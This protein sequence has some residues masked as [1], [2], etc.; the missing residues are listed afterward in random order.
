M[1]DALVS[2]DWVAQRLGE[3]GLRVIEVSATRLEDY[4]RA[5]LPGAVV[6]DWQAELIPDED[7]SSGHIVDPDR[8]AA[9][10]RRL[11]VRPEDELAF[12]GDQG[13]R[14][15]IRALWTF[16]YYRHPGALHVMDGGREKWQAEGRPMTDERPS[17]EPSDYAVPT[18]RRPDIRATRDDVLAALNDGR[19]AI[20]DVRTPEEYDG[21]DVRAARGGRIPGARHIY[22]EDA[23][24][25]HGALKPKAE[26]EALYG[27]IDRDTTVTTYCQLGVRAAH[28]WFVLHHVLCYPRVRNYD[29]SW[30]EWGDRDDSP[31][32]GETAPF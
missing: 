6:I 26:L 28:T 3:R 12:Y 8:F 27:G 11:G 21:I 1:S 19:H 13:G 30:R 32:E 14:H 23:L 24:A 29:G 22:W 2:T 5:H 18:G 31:I 15:A 16:E 9:L 7:E 20:V 4:A 25:E 10:A 17:V